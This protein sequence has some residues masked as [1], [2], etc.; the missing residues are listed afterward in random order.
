MDTPGIKSPESKSNN[1]YKP[2]GSRDNNS[3]QCILTLKPLQ[4][5]T[6]Y[7]VLGNLNHRRDDSE[8]VTL[9]YHEAPHPPSSFISRRSC[10]I[11]IA[12][13]PE[14]RCILSRRRLND[15]DQWRLGEWIHHHNH[16]RILWHKLWQK[17]SHYCVIPCRGYM[18]YHTGQ[19]REGKQVGV[20]A[21]CDDSGTN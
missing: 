16:H 7:Q 1:L 6:C 15:S 20:L 5:L 8:P 12:P 2:R 4:Q 13:Q 18:G 10:R 9:H 21:I 3:I 17:W 14:R 19:R 11:S